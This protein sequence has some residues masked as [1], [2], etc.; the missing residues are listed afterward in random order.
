MMHQCGIRLATMAVGLAL[1]AAAIAA[2]LIGDEPK[3]E[4]GKVKS[5]ESKGEPMKT[6]AGTNFASALGLNLRNLTTLGPRIDQAELLPDP[7]ALA[8]MARELAIAEQIAKKKADLTSTALLKEAVYLAKLRDDPEELQAVASLSEKEARKELVALA[9]KAAK[10]ADDRKNG[11]RKKGLNGTLHV[12]SRVNRSM[13]VLVNG[14]WKGDIPANGDLYVNVNQGPG[15]VTTVVARWI[16]KSSTIQLGPELYTE[17]T[18]I[19]TP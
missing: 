3:K 5:F 11:E 16:G 7:V 6:W 18:W 17:Y 15:T 2:P 1:L 4:S 8:L 10:A 19:V 14:Q 9:D 13:T 12:D